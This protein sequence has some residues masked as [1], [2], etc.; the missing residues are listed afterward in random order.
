MHFFLF[1][2][3]LYHVS[4]TIYGIKMYNNKVEVTLH[5]IF[6]F[7]K[8]NKFHVDNTHD[9]RPKKHSILTKY[10]DEKEHIEY[11]I[12]K[13][14]HEINFYGCIMCGK[15]HFCE[16][17]P[18][19]CPIINTMDSKVCLFSG[20]IVSCNQM[21]VGNWGDEIICDKEAKVIYDK[22]K[23]IYLPKKRLPSLN[24][25]MR[26]FYENNSNIKLSNKINNNN[27][28]NLITLK[29]IKQEPISKMK[30]E[31]SS[32]PKFSSDDTIIENTQDYN[33]F[34]G[35]DTDQVNPIIV[36]FRD[37][38]DD[39]FSYLDDYLNNNLSILGGECCYFNTHLL[40]LHLP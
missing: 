16:K 9:C 4:Y 31:I 20:S 33:N 8:Y 26:P 18:K 1:F 21:V 13:P 32:G 6:I 2:P 14:F 22:Q 38:L 7:C 28:N 5:W 10:G 30:L 3:S 34:K 35:I 37:T 29:K 12:I 11:F 27:I 19:I 17:S 39:Y 24:N 40:L 25:N 36:N 15:Y 23:T